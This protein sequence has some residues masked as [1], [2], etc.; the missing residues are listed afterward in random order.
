MNTFERDIVRE[1]EALKRQ[2][3]EIAPTKRRVPIVASYNT[4]TAQNIAN[5]TTV[6]TLIDFNL[7]ERDTH[8]AV[9]TG[10]SWRFTA[11][12]AG[13]YGVSAA[14][15]YQST[16]TWALG[17]VASLEVWKNNNIYR[18]L[19]RKDDLNSGGV[20]IFAQLAGSTTVYLDAGNYIDLRTRQSSGAALTL[21]NNSMYNYVSIWRI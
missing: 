18:Y 9:T 4:A 3:A 19:R 1:I 20:A 8:S 15:L 5:S 14:I 16:A 11:P 12:V 13:D 7:V 2:V 6:P 17:E 21:F 10:A